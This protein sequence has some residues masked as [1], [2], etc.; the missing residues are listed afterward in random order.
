MQGT[1]A[2]PTKACI[3]VDT[4]GRDCYNYSEGLFLYKNCVYIPPISMCDDIASISRCGIDSIKTNAIINSKIESKKLE[5]GPN[6]CYNIH[7][8]SNLDNWCNLK[9]HSSKMVQK[10]SEVYL[11]DV[12]CNSGKNEKNITKKANQGLGAVSQIFVM[13]NQ[14]SLGYYFYEM[15]LLFRDTNLVSKLVSSSE[16]WYNISKS[17]YQK[18]QA[19]DE[20]FLRRLFD[21]PVTTPKE[22]LYLEGGKMP[23]KFII[24]SRRVMYWWHIVSLD[25][26]ELLYKVY[27]GQTLNPDKD[28]WICQ[29]EQDKKDLHFNLKDEEIKSFSKDQFK[30]L[31]RSKVEIYAAKKLEELRI[32][33]SKT[34]N[35]KFDGFH[36]AEYLLSK[37]LSTEEVQTLFKLRNRMVQV[38]GN[39]ANGNKDNMW[40]KTCKL[41]TETQEHLVECPAIRLRTK[42]LINFQEV[43]C[44]MIFGTIKNQ[45]KIAKSYH[46]ILEARKDILQDMEN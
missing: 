28:D 19:I 27:M 11:G 41:F 38:K 12:I 26:S 32:S 4:L 2:S 43:S 5:F 29:L 39:F 6:K 15:A 25:K 16:V 36:P 13:L 14:I 10:D 44:E 20:M 18:L 42:S 37:N 17:K 45:E 46:I 9:V 40:C 34:Q 1:V 31:V 33:H 30:R 24:K 22:S 23:V 8:G 35:L 21:V 7:V 3:Q